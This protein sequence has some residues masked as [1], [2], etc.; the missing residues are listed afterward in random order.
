[1]YSRKTTP[2]KDKI[3]NDLYDIM[4]KAL[5]EAFD[6]CIKANLTKSEGSRE[7]LTMMATAMDALVTV[8]KSQGIKL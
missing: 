8:T 7:V 4:E 6:V 3:R 5:E 2:S 1:M